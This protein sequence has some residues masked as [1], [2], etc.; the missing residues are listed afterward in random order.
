MRGRG[1][2]AHIACSVPSCAAPRLQ[3]S[4][5]RAEQPVTINSFRGEVC[6]RLRS[7][8]DLCLPQLMHPLDSVRMKC[9]YRCI[10]NKEIV[11]NSQ[12]LVK[13]R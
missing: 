11:F 5:S 3:V 9:H 7:F 6:G 4:A 1:A 2:R 12:K 10:W 8:H 13:R